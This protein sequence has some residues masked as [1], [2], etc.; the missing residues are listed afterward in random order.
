MKNMWQTVILQ[1]V[2]SLKLPVNSEYNNKIRKSESA[3]TS[4][5]STKN[6]GKH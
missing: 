2:P 1:S 4:D 3:G 6:P 5:K